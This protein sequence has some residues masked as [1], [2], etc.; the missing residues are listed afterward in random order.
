MVKVVW[1][2][3]DTWERVDVAGFVVHGDAVAY[4]RSGN[5]HSPVPRYQVERSL[6]VN[7]KQAV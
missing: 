4:A 1:T 3:C 2:V 5:A 6:S 7:G